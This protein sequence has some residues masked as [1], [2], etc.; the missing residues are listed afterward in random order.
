MK[1]SSKKENFIKICPRCGSIYVT[2][3]FT[4]NTWLNFYVCQTCGY[5]SVLFPE[6]KRE[7]AKKLPK[8]KVN[9]Y[10]WR[11]PTENPEIIG[12]PYAWLV[13]TILF[14]LVIIIL[15]IVK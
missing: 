9:Y 3:E 6:V 1:K 14:I 8:R 12:F 4:R 2:R 15:S 11:V 13:L 7:E 5:R 10:P